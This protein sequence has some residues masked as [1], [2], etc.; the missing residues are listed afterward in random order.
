[1]QA[2]SGATTHSSR[3]DRGSARRSDVNGVVEAIPAAARSIAMERRKDTGPESALCANRVSVAGKK[4]A[5]VEGEIL[6]RYR[7]S[8]DATA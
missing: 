2:A 8:N 3:R 7:L 4:S 5:D 6:C 1:M